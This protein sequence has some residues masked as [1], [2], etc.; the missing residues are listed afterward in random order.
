MTLALSLAAAIA[1]A[2]LLGAWRSHRELRRWLGRDPAGG[3]R[4]LRAL[5]RPRG[6]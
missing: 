6:R 2:T 1:L 3:G 5:A 4:L